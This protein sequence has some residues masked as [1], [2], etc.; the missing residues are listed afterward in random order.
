[1]T[2]YQFKKKT[3]YNTW[4][5]M[6]QRCNGTSNATDI[7]NYQARGISFVP[8]WAEFS[9]FWN[10]MSNGWKIGLTLDRIDNNGDY[11]KKNCRWA[12][13]KI[14]AINRRNTKFFA[15]N[16]KSHTLTDWADILGLKRSTLAQRFYVYNWPIEKIFQPTISHF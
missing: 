2:K 14:Q 1:M 4:C 7:K 6:K 15:F 16:G 10:D 3:L 9:N 13:R 5:R 12:D 8:E 11:S